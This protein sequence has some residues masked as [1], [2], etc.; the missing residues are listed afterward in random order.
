MINL[1][2]YTILGCN[3]KSPEDCYNCGDYIVICDDERVAMMSKF[4][5]V[6][7]HVDRIGR[8]WWFNIATQDEENFIKIRTV[9]YDPNERIVWVESIKKS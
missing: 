2:K 1:S 4:N 6:E 5:I 9:E 8:E 3:V 7:G